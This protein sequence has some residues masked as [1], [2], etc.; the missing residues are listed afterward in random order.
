MKG[1]GA[2][3]FFLDLLPFPEFISLVVTSPIVC[4]AHLS[5]EGI[6]EVKVVPAGAKGCA[7][8]DGQGMPQASPEAARQPGQGST[9]A[10]VRWLWRT[11]RLHTGL[12]TLLW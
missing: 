7:E 11:Q 12:K 10:V 4:S 6:E 2:L 8:L 9:Q 3:S 5:L 1:I